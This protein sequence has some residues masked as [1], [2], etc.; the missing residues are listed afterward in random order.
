[1][2]LAARKKECI[3]LQ[4]VLE[5]E[6]A[7]FIAIYGRRRVG[8]TYLINQFF[9]NKG[10]FFELT[11]RKGASRKG[12]LYNF[13]TVFSDIFCK[14]EETPHSP[15]HWDE[16]FDLLRRKIE[17]LKEN[18]KV[19]LFFDE[20]P[21]L[22]SQK[23]G[24][25]EALDLFW[26]RYMSRN[27]RVILIVC[28]SA[29][30]WMIK[31]I[32]SN[33]TGLH[34]RLTR[35]SINLKPFSLQETE[36]YLFFRGIT[37]DRKQIVDIYMAL[38]GVAYYLDLVPKGKSSAEIISYLFFEQGA[39][40]VEEFYNLFRSL[41]ENAEKHVQVVKA[42]AQ[43]VSGLTQ[44]EIFQ[45]VKTLSAGGSSVSLLE[46]LEHCGFIAT[47]PAFGKKKKETKYRL[48]DNFTLFY[49]HF[50][51]GAKKVSSAYWLRKKGSPSYS[52]WAGYAFENIC[53]QHYPQ[54]ISALKLSVVAE[55]YSS[56]RYIPPQNHE[57]IGA[58]IDLVI[59]R[60]DS[61][62]TLCEMKFHHEEFLISKEYAATLLHKKH[63]FKE[64][65]KTRKTIFMTLITPYGVKKEANYLRCVDSQLTLNSLFAPLM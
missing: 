35:P 10:I 31:K 50:V 22:A 32:I 20:L 65:T 53:I 34:N 61:C 30:E 58:Q 16:A 33:K 64:K 51:S 46:E 15:K 39:P 45:K 43:T 14:K 44:I 24:F 17:Q 57:E 23:S 38:G 56:W 29:A 42:L 13:S 55:L 21:W 63:C 47:L 41:Y 5:S 7:E 4:E 59:D 62:I 48:V 18:K 19:I 54:I 28:G 8:K 49:L 40:L 11:G 60:A 37:L 12:Q 26:N 2:I 9:Q 6:K 25:L 52:T 3:F 1:M 27:P 36:E